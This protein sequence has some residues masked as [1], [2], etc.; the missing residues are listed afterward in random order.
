[1]SRGLDYRYASKYAILE[2]RYRVMA[3]LAFGNKQPI[4]R[5]IY[6]KI[7]KYYEKKHYNEIMSR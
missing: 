7:A 2:Y 5:F 6:S 3:A 4:R 1:M